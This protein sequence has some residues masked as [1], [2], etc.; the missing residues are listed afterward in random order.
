M[1]MTIIEKIF[2]RKAGL[3]SVGPGD[4]VVVDVDM[5]VLIDLQFATMWLQ[6]NRIHDA[7][8]LAI[9]MDHAVPAPTLKDAAGGPRARKFAAD[10]GIERFYDVGR[11]GIC[12]Q[13]IAENGL[14]RP[15]EVLACTDSHTCAAGAYN[16]AARGL[17]PAEVYSIMCTGSTWFQIAPT[18]RYELVGIMPESVS[19]KDV[20]LHIADA[21]GDAANLNLEFGGPGLTSVPMHDRRT[22]ATQGAEVS[23]DFSTFEPDGLLTSFLD[24]RGVTGYRAATPDPD[25][26]YRDV[27]HV[28][29]DALEPYVARPGTVSHNGLPV[30]QL[31]RQKVDQAFIGSCANGQ[32]E[33]LEVAANVLRGRT[34]ASGVRLLVTPASQAVYREAMRLG[35]LQDI[36]DAGGV[37]TNSTCGACFGYHMG[38][39][40]PG[41]VCVTSSTRNF[42]GR[43][44]STEAQIFMASPA[45]VAASAI[46]GYITD[47]RSVTA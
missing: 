33:D 40:G 47:A 29:L 24:E 17:G 22:I 14:A 21:Y 23:A 5:T 43:M 8:K 37:V 7:D 4:T 9:V 31:G 45:T 28:D 25:A 27:R 36:A 46:T 12:H 30:S 16:T 20:F 11:H 42:T 44:G 15:G 6:P 34:V 41:E 38:V 18:I 32:L 13:V 3:D 2:A 19:G 26:T 10:F 1:G 39:V 35:Y